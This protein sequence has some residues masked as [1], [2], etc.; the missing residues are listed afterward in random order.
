MATEH[1]KDK[2]VLGWGRSSLFFVGGDY[3]GRGSSY[4]INWTSAEPSSHNISV[5][6][7]SVCDHW[8]N[9]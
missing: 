6:A 9:K 7:R 1:N 4:E 5:G 2:I 8:R 3:S